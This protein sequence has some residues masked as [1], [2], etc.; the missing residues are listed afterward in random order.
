M[1]DQYSKDCTH[2][3]TTQ[4]MLHL[5]ELLG[6]SESVRRIQ[7]SRIRFPT[8]FPN[9]TSASDVP[10]LASEFHLLSPTSEFNH[11]A[12][13]SRIRPS[14][15]Q[16]PNPTSELDLRIRPRSPTS[17]SGS[18]ESDLR[19][20]VPNPTYEFDL[21]SQLSEFEDRTTHRPTDRPND[22]LTDRPTNPT[23]EL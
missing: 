9:P 7:P 2:E 14:L 11:R 10:N 18:P 6:I 16:P 20:R 13:P 22:R 15:N 8:P 4:T 17:E 21:R 12:R 5:N 23:C 3:K 19:M 1:H